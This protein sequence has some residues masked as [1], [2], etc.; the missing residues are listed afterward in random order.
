MIR[1][2]FAALI[3]A[4]LLQV[5]APSRA[6]EPYPI[7][8]IISLTGQAAFIGKGEESTLRAAEAVINKSGGIHRR[9]VQ[10]VIQD[11]QSNP[12]VAV[13]LFNAIVA[14][15]VPVMFGPTL[16]G[17]CYAVAPL[18]KTQIVNYCFSP[19]LHPAAGSYSFSATA[20]TVDLVATALRYLKAHGV[21]KLALLQTTDASG[22]DGETVIGEDLKLPEFSEIQLAA[23]EHFAP[24]DLSVDAQLLRIRNTGA[25]AI[26]TWISGP[27]FGTVLRG[28][29]NAGMDIPVVSSAANVSY[30]QIAQ[31]KSF[32]PKNTLFI[33]PRF[34]NPKLTAPANVKRAQDEFYKAMATVNVKPDTLA[35]I[36]WNPVF[37]VVEALRH[38]PENAT[39]QQV[40]DYIEN[41]RDF[42]GINGLM[43]YRD[44]S[45]R[46][47]SPDSAVVVRYDVESSTFVAISKPGGAPL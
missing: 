27:P 8:V 17:P 6:A 23:T 31:Y 39:A 46:G 44:G 24:A 26:I 36:A 32:L 35:S 9:P 16:A 25:Q 19:A 42:P 29:N 38:L 22:Q 7:Y 21:R 34:I 10:F 5:A 37:V 41:V 3:A 28:V 20:S 13:Q 15:G 47:E 45:Q 30:A 11:D 33:S 12:A 43:N 18:V 40:H 1:A 14:K 4:L 2:L